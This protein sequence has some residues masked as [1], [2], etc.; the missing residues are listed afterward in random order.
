MSKKK[1]IHEKKDNAVDIS[2]YLYRKTMARAMPG[3]LEWLQDVVA[4]T[5][6]EL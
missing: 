6:N 4:E 3:A 1:S 2:T 5:L